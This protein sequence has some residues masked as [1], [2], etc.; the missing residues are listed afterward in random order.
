MK[1]GGSVWIPIQRR[2][3]RVE[4]NSTIAGPIE[5]AITARSNR[6]SRRVSPW[7]RPPVEPMLIEEGFSTMIDAPIATR[8]WARIVAENRGRK[9]VAKN[10]AKWKLKS[11][12]F[13]RGIESHDPMPQGSTSTTPSKR[14]PRPL[15]M[16]HDFRA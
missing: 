9:I 14:R 15:P 11:S 12:R 6:K 10:E 4:R 1:I 16:G 13:L 7:N 2:L 3:Q 5:T 8:S